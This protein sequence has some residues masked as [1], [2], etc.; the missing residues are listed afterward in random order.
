MISKKMAGNSSPC[1]TTRYIIRKKK[2]STADVATP[3]IISERGGK[4]DITV[5]DSELDFS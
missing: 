5:Y 1:S 4:K 2:T 3:L